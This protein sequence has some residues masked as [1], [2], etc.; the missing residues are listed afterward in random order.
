MRR[1]VYSPCDLCKENPD[2]PPLW[3]LKAERVVH[4]QKAQ[5]VRYNN[6][7]L[8]MWGVPV[9]YSPYFQHPDPTVKRRSGFLP[10]LFGTMGEVGEFL[11]VPYYIEIGRASGRERVCQYVWISVVAVSLQKK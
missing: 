11:R 9:L 6:V 5:E 2:R 10:P 7:F 3:Q 4:D 8:E 1:A